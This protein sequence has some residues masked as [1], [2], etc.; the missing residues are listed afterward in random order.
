M[1]EVFPSPYMRALGR[2]TAVLLL[3]LYFANLTLFRVV[4]LG[5][6]SQKTGR[7]PLEALLSKLTVPPVPGALQ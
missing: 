3:K 6:W 5:T 4:C 2:S 7:S 1:V